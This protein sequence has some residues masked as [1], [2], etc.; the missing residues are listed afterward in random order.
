VTPEALIT[1]DADGLPIRAVDERGQL[2]MRASWRDGALVRARLRLPDDRW[3]A[4]HPRADSHPL[5]GVCDVF[6]LTDDAPDAAAIQALARCQA[7][8]W[9][10]PAAIPPLDR[11]GALPAG[12]GTAVLNFLAQRAR[13]RGATL[14]YRGPYPTGALFDALLECFAVSGDL[15]AAFARFSADVEDTALTGTAREAPVDFTPAPFVRTWAA[16][17]VC[18]QKRSKINKIHINKYAFTAIPIGARR[19][20]PHPDGVSAT[21]VLGGQPHAEVARFS[22]DGSLLSGPHPLPPVTGGLVGRPLPAALSRALATALPPRAPAA[23]RSTLR[24]VLADTPLIWGDPGADAAA[25]RDGAIVLHPV[26]VQR[27]DGVALLNALAAA[28]E[29]LAHR[30]AQTRLAALID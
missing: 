5:F 15:A 29:P 16:P 20:L 2:A 6:S 7:V 19:L 4:I 18:V 9:A 22:P 3:L 13:A 26:L 12:A 11:P 10:A 27:L 17:R 21:L 23:L 30:L 1:T 8:D 14:R 24:A 28:I 25:A